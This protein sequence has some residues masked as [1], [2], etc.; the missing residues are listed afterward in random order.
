MPTV[1]N[2]YVSLFVM[3]AWVL[4]R[5]KHF[6]QHMVRI[7]AEIPDEHVVNSSHIPAKTPTQVATLED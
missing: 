4:G 6:S 3:C 7:P 1:H 2:T 5:A